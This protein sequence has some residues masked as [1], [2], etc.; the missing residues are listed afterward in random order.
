MVLIGERINST[1]K[2]IN[3]AIKSRNAAFILKEAVDQRDAGADFIDVNCAMTAG[4]EVQDID[5]VISVIQ[6]EMSDVNIC[7]DSPNYLAVDR[8]LKVYKAKG[9]VLINSIT[10]DENRIAG[11]LP[12]AME[13]GA[14]VIALTMTERGMPHTARERF[15]IA[16]TIIQK[17]RER[18]FKAEHLLFDPLIRP[19]ATEP[20][21]AGEFLKA[22]P[23]IKSLGGV[24]TVCGLS[25]IS[26]GLPRRT[27]INAAFL[28]MA[29]SHGLDAAILDPLDPAI[30]STLRASRALLGADE[31][32]GAYIKAFREGKLA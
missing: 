7:I 29:V 26:F 14:H 4:D 19:I 9:Q 25:N 23:L 27:V 10:A 20:D 15:E 28:S 8:A 11:I 24:R 21:Q 12:L 30:I 3:E 13:Y 31:Y 1:R 5:W 16:A 32:C 18:G 2:S 22:I 17:A 6:S